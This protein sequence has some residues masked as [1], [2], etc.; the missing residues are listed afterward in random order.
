MQ[1]RQI[2][3]GSLQLA[4][5]DNRGSG[6][7][8]VALHGFLDNAMS[9]SPLFPFFN[10][11]HF[12]ALDLAGHG[13][14]DHRPAGAHYHHADY[15]QDIYAALSE[16]TDKPCVLLGHSLGG[17]LATQFAALFP[18]KVKAV[19]S[20][21]ACGP[22]TK[23]EDS[24]TMQMRESILSRYKK[25][26]SLLKPVE[27]EMAVAARCRAA[28][29]PQEHA[30]SILRRNLKKADDGL[31]YW[32]SDPRLRT[33]STLRLTEA[34]AQNMMS[35]ITCPVWFGAVH[36]SFKDVAEVYSV[37]KAWFSHSQIDYFSGG[38]HIHMEQPE[39][40]SAAIRQ[41]VVQ[42]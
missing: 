19:V 9:F 28:E 13:L 10:D 36:G 20:I 8:I 4:A 7:L 32:G 16:I 29:I 41:F 5:L 35:S 39:A 38:H 18:E 26:E 2:S 30:K 42:L 15:L 1:P 40:V 34:Q 11:F 27:L 22:L 17:I 37:R 31:L 14:S 6:D 33:K 23:A 3:A 25:Q 24:T 21:D 12:I